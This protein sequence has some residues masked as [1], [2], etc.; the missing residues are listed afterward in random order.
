MA[1]D[2]SFVSEL[3]EKGNNAYNRSEFKK[4]IEFYEPALAIAR[5]LEDRQA[6]GA[7]LGNLKSKTGNLKVMLSATSGMHISIWER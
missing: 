5:E 4:A 1:F 2:T 6:E 7:A 3:I